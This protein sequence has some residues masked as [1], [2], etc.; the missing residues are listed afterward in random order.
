MSTLCRV[1][2]VSL[3]QSQLILAEAH[4]EIHQLLTCPTDVLSDALDIGLASLIETPVVHHGDVFSQAI[5]IIHDYDRAPSCHRVATKALLDSCQS[6]EPADRSANL[7]L[8]LVKS[9]FAARLAIC[10]LNGAGAAIPTECMSMIPK[11]SDDQS[12]LCR[13]TGYHC[14]PQEKS[15]PEFNPISQPETNACLRAL[16][17]KPQWWTSYSNARQNAVLMCHAA[18]E[19]I[20]HGMSQLMSAHIDA[21]HYSDQLLN[22]YRAMSETTEGLSAA[23]AQSA[24]ESFAQLAK[25]KAFASAV[26]DFQAQLTKDLE[27]ERHGARKIISNLVDEVQSEWHTVFNS[28]FG[29]A[30]TMA[31]KV[32]DINM[33]SFHSFFLH[34]QS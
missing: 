3:S 32:D 28:I 30:N 10:E 16:E 11:A 31:T 22:T 9:A 19:Q 25:Q 17:S 27:L 33:V 34:I 13:S 23:L 4:I 29:N 18:R 5:R 15:K 24:S 21:N 1:S 7:A 12:L 14:D 2:E 26:Q 6:L 20:E 8:D